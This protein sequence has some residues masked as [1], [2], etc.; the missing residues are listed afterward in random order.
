MIAAPFAVA[1]NGSVHRLNRPYRS[2]VEG[3]EPRDGGVAA[4]AVQCGG[5]VEAAVVARAARREELPER[6]EGSIQGAGVAP[7]PFSAPSSSAAR[8]PATTTSARDATKASRAQRSAL[9]RSPARRRCRPPPACRATR[10]P[11][12]V[13]ARFFAMSSVCQR[14]RSRGALR[15]RLRLGSV[16]HER[17]ALLPWFLKPN[18]AQLAVLALLFRRGERRRVGNHNVA[19]NHDRR[20]S[21]R[22]AVSWLTQSLPVEGVELHQGHRRPPT[23]RQTGRTRRRRPTNANYGPVVCHCQ[24]RDWTLNPGEGNRRTTGHLGFSPGIL[25]RWPASCASKSKVKPRPPGPKV[26]PVPLAESWSSCGTGGGAA[27]DSDGNASTAQPRMTSSRRT[28][29]ALALVDRMTYL[30][31]VMDKTG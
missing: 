1:A 2:A 31:P 26:V 6:P 20:Q 28:R 29:E 12:T 3:E 22:N 11:Q 24:A 25:A 9:P 21:C 23:F 4:M 15:S 18:C 16:L 27:A 5:Q 13:G 8:A 10:A 19:F 30:C 7:S 14:P 17:Y